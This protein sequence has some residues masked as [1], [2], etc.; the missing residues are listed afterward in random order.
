LVVVATVRMVVRISMPRSS[1]NSFRFK[2]QFLII[3]YCIFTYKF[4]ILYKELIIQTI[5]FHDNNENNLFTVFIFAFN[6]K[7]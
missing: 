2:D 5:S 1:L 6:Q 4:Q 7:L 3:K